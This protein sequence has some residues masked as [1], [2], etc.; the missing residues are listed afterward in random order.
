MMRHGTACVKEYKLSTSYWLIHSYQQA[1][2]RRTPSPPSESFVHGFSV[3]S[4]CLF[5]RSTKAPDR[6][7]L[8]PFSGISPLGQ[9]STLRQERQ[10]E[11]EPPHLYI[12]FAR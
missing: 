1:E 6:C 12:E 3:K 10:F 9:R 8:S 4:G 7:R 2:L 5:L 11:R